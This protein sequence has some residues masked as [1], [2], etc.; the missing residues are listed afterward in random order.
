[1]RLLSWIVL[2]FWI[3]SFL[4][5]LLNLVLQK[6]VPLNAPDDGP[7]VSI[8]I[9]ARDEERAIERTVRALLSQTYRNL[10]V[11][12]VDDRST[13]GTS[14][15]LER[16][17]VGDS[18]LHIVRGEEPPPGWLGKP[19]A[20]HQGS[21]VASGEIL[22]FIDADIIYAP[23]A[24]A[25]G[26][27]QFLDASVPMITFLP[28]IEMRG[29]WENVALPQLALMLF[30]FLP[31]W[32]S[33][34]TRI[35]WLAVGSGTGNMIAQAD[36]EAIGGHETLKS[37]VVDDVGLAYHVRRS[38]RRTLVYRADDLVSVRIYHGG[39]EIVQGFTKNAFAILRRSYLGTAAA[40]AF[41][42]LFHVWP[43]VAACIGDPVN[44][45]TV[46]VITVTRIILFRSLRYPLTYAVF[47]HPLMMLFWAYIFLRS[48]WITG[49]RK[50]LLWR[51]RSYDIR[52]A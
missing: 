51:G 42:L 23:Q 1:M 8:V 31:L 48:M 25:A 19:W 13:D 18:R 28:R 40:V 33:N 6:R 39:W 30:T 41:G 36:Y 10:E 9:P 45:A 20:L 52:S 26:V 47:A 27:A 24:I 15:I 4:R 37:A 32:L 16:L 46:V 12:V 7:L 3:S 35:P 34:R 49:V 14:A 38:G 21:R 17:A 22:L 29:F 5:T 50:K 2:I 11:M 44:I 43:Y